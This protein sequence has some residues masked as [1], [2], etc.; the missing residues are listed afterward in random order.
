LLPPIHRAAPRNPTDIVSEETVARLREKNA[1]LA[2]AAWQ[3]GYAFFTAG[4]AAAARNW[5]ERARSLAPRD[6]TI[7]LVLAMALLQL[8]EPDVTLFEEIT[9]TDD[10]R[11]AW[12]G[13]AAARRKNGDVEGAA[14][15]LH[16]AL[17]AHAAPAD[18]ALAELGDAVAQ[19]AR[20]PG[21]CSLDS[22]GRLFLGGLVGG[23]AIALDG[24][25]WKGGL[26]LPEDWDRH[27]RVEVSVDGVA[28]IGSPLRPDLMR[29]C[30]G[31][32][33]CR[34]GGVEGWAWYPGDPHSD[35]LLRIG[36][37]DAPDR[38]RLVIPETAM[39]VSGH[40]PLARPRRFRIEA[41]DL[42]GLD[43]PIHVRGTDRRDLLGSPLD[44]SAEPRAAASIA[45]TLA[46]RF[47]ASRPPQRNGA[48]APAFLPVNADLA[49]P[50]R[51][52]RSGRARGIA[53]VVPVYRG[54]EQTL[55]CLAEVLATMPPGTSLVVIDDASPEPDMV[56]RIRA[57]APG[58][59]RLIRHA[60]NRGFPASANAGIRAAPRA[61]I[62]LLN[63]DTLV[64]PSWIERLRDAAYDADDIGTVTPL[65]NDA[66]ILSYPSI[67]GGNAV[68]NRSETR[69]LAAL[70]DRVNAGRRVDIPTGVGFCLYVRRDCLDEVGLLRE[71]VFA[72]GYGEENDFCLRARHLGWRHVAALDV[73]VAHVGGQ[74]FGA[75]RHHLIERNMVVLNRL[76]PGYAALIA[77]H[78][79]AD[80]LAEGRRRL[81]AAR[82][83]GRPSRRVRGV[84]LITHDLGGGVQRQV[85]ARCRALEAEGRKA[86]VLQPIPLKPG[87]CRLSDGSSGYPNLRFRIPEELPA[88]ERLLAGERLEHAEL[89][90]LVG[91]DH[92]V[93]SL[94]DRLGL[95]YDVHVHD[96]AWFCPRISLIGVNRRYCGEPDV[97]ACEACVAD[98]GS[99][100]EEEISVPALR[101]RSAADL[102]R[103]RRVIAPSHDA[104]ARLRRHFPGISTSVVA[105]EREPEPIPPRQER[106]RSEIL[107][108]VIGAIGVEKGYD[109]L[110]GCARDAAAQGLRLRFVVVG[111]TV[112]DDRLLRTGRV[113]ITGEY[114]A[115]ALPVLIARQRADLAWLPSLWP[116]TWSFVLTEAWRA[117]LDVAAFDLGAPAERIRRCGRGVLLPLGLPPAGVNRALLNY[118]RMP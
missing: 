61:D 109:I 34:D 82:F 8:G 18:P 36:S 25:P 81:D 72:Q 23:A 30:D 94:C 92:R 90:H 96:Y 15:A 58:R 50:A 84:L 42:A 24:R 104:A 2:H 11:A 117:G 1:A 101:Q 93:L 83:R 91:H 37:A 44:P 22:G 39:L 47:P 63:N 12:L 26:Q 16:R 19:A 73:F 67:E 31:F 112:D 53:V 75:A 102:A 17:S 3:Q 88:L 66:T 32:V 9:R 51:P 41:P 100:I 97:A 59:I 87:L 4:D 64:A 14:A 98:A 108:C 38:L 79:A 65:S 78:Q 55:A 52:R 35:P 54:V 29:R 49:V 95:P 21:W 99:N 13:L 71:D 45:Q 118:A 74:S 107:V 7:L 27:A 70:A 85:E 33:T 113:F 20:R 86:L 77:A 5:L 60:T 116:E 69:R 89:H 28:L 43:G 56:A 103:A 76:H 111:H 46:R 114:R 115:A 80:P 106:G 68:P 6:R 105:W 57:L 40:A 10:V 48:D 110:L 62:L